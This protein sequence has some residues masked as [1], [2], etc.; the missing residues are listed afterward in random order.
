MTDGA[1]K[2]LLDKKL[3]IIHETF[4]QEC[5]KEFMKEEKST[6]VGCDECSRWYHISCVKVDLD[7]YWKCAKCKHVYIALNMLFI[8]VNFIGLKVKIIRLTMM[9]EIY[10]CNLF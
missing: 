8:F 10:Y 3:K 2:R 4:C 5:E 9:I 6:M 7:K 1:V